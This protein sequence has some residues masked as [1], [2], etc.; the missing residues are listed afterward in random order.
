M[1]RGSWRVLL[2]GVR[3]EEGGGMKT[4][5]TRIV[6]GSRVDRVLAIMERSD[7]SMNHLE[8]RDLMLDMSRDKVRADALRGDL[9]ERGLIV[10]TVRYA[11]S[12]CAKRILERVAK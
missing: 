12:D 8:F 2:P 6:E 9:L 5:A 7:S 11:I 10:K 3:C 4:Q 1:V